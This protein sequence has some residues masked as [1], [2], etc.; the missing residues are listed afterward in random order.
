MAPP[1]AFPKKF[2][3]KVGGEWLPLES[4]SANQQKALFRQVDRGCKI[5]AAMSGMTCREHSPQQKQTIRCDLCKL[6]KPRDEYS[7]SS[8]KEDTIK[9]KVCVA[10]VETQ[11][12][13]IVPVPLATGHI[14]PE[15]IEHDEQWEQRVQSQN[16][17]GP[18]ITNMEVPISGLAAL[19]LTDEEQRALASDSE[20][21]ALLA[22]PLTLSTTTKTGSSSAS[23][24]QT[25]SVSVS[26]VAGSRVSRPLPPHLAAKAARAPSVSSNTGSEA[27]SAAAGSVSTATTV[28]EAEEE[29]KRSRQVMY[30]AWDQTGRRHD[31]VRVPSAASR[32]DSMSLLDGES[33][34]VGS[35]EWPELKAA[36]APEAEPVQKGSNKWPKPLLSASERKKAVPQPRFSNARP[37]R[38][39]QMR[40]RYTYLDNDEEFD[41]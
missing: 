18:Y 25:A 16:P 33:I 4:F 19:G 36:P 13:R 14:S 39:L 11:E 28:R 6:Y 2:R 17:V 1:P 38:D 22:A 27:P 41:Y 21:G 7:K 5:D 40:Q 3:C 30:N 35:Q 34:E 31:A 8:L 29:A 9:C 26:S 15:E 10:W 12:P 32:T 23:Q 37:E 24:S 20:V